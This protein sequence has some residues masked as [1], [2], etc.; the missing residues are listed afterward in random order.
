MDHYSLG[1]TQEDFYNLQ[2]VPNISGASFEEQQN[3]IN[4]QLLSFNT[5]GG[6]QK[7]QHLNQQP[8]LYPMN[9]S[10]EQ[11]DDDEDEYDEDEDDEADF[12]MGKNGKMI[13][14]P[15]SKRLKMYPNGR[16]R[17]SK[18]CHEC[19]RRHT[20]CGFQRPCERCKRLGLDCVDVQSIK[21][22]GR[23]QKKNEYSPNY[24]HSFV[25]NIPQEGVSPSVDSYQMSQ[26]QLPPPTTHSNNS[27]N[28]SPNPNMLSDN[29]FS[30]NSQ[31]P[32]QPSTIPNRFSNYN[33]A[34]PHNPHQLNQLSCPPHLVNEN[35]QYGLNLGGSANEEDDGFLLSEIDNMDPGT[36]SVNADANK[37]EKMGVIVSQDVPSIQYVS[38]SI[39]QKLGHASPDAIKS[40]YDLFIPLHVN[41][42]MKSIK[43]DRQ[44][45]IIIMQTMENGTE[46]L[47][48]NHLKTE[49][50]GRALVIDKNGSVVELVTKA[51]R[52]Y[53]RANPSKLDGVYTFLF[54]N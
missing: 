9:F 53:N 31:S 6:A 45:R 54:W 37:H 49:H 11:Y 24:Q 52:V 30:H 22:R 47:R 36:F 26:Q 29:I 41:W 3:H 13:R 44:K 15:N 1:G 12:I 5:D 39:I 42:S 34:I 25:N 27:K 18:A 20:R 7:N 8:Y 50:Q 32:T 46:M 2:Q 23:A 28:N 21:K 51:F 17:A 38:D 43:E 33:Q 16:K 4:R 10:E 40:Y 19:Q 35:E 48:Q 14:D